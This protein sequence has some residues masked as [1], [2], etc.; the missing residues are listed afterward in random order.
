MSLLHMPDPDAAIRRV[1]RSTLILTVLL[2][3]ALGAWTRSPV[4]VLGAT[5]AA[6]LMMLNFRGLVALSDRLLGQ[7]EGRPTALQ[8]GLLAGRYVLLGVGLCAMVLLPGVGPIP[9]VLGMSVLV[10]AVLVEAACQLFAGP[11]RRG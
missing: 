4:A 10:V 5:A 2:A 3:I 11:A 7:S 6:A 8:A 9:V 1:W